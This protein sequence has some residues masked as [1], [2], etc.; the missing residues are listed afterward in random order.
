[1]LVI[2]DLRLPADTTLPVSITLRLPKDANLV[3]VASQ[4]ADGS[5]LNA[6]YQGPTAG[7][8]WQTIAVQIPTAAIYHIE[9]YEPLSRAG[10]ERDFSYLWAGDYAVD[11]LAISVRLPRDATN[12]SSDPSME[13]SLDPD[14]TPYLRKDFGALGAEQ[15]LPLQL[16]YKKS[17]DSLTASRQ[18]LQPSQP[19]GAG[20]PGRVMLSN[21]LPY[22]LGVLGMALIVGG[23][24]YF[25][26]SSRGR[27][28]AR[29]RRHRRASE[30]EDRQG[31][32]VYCHQCGTRA[33]P[34]DRFCRVCGIRLRQPE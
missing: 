8:G 30:R 24:V 31:S 3:A 1:M 11:D 4:A 19:L 2:Y 34:G 7:D 33:H 28:L 17:S 25:W 13:S 27:V 26:Q 5:L 22:I 9:Y 15:Q 6:D 29:E 23:A 14:G 18:D 32:E 10:D 20:T 16:T 21:Y 12:V